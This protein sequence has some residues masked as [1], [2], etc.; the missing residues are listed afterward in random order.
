MIEVSITMPKLIS[1]YNETFSFRNMKVF[2]NDDTWLRFPFLLQP[3]MKEVDGTLSD[4][5]KSAENFS[6][7]IL[8]CIDRFAPS[9]TRYVPKNTSHG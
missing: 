2:E 4:L 6:E 5:N 1:R 3:K 7:I 9:Q 8:S